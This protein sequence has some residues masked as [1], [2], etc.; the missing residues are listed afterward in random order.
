MKS[1]R[2]LKEAADTM[3]ESPA[4]LQL[5]YLQASLP[6]VNS[7]IYQLLNNPSFLPDTELH[8]SREELDHHFPAADRSNQPVAQFDKEMID[9]LLISKVNSYVAKTKGSTLLAICS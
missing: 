9:V 4:A 8:R 6:S 1:A 3:C 5:R 2:A 7:N